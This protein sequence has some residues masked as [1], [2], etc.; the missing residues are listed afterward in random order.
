MISKYELF[1]TSVSSL[2]RDIQKIE[3]I[4]MAKFGL[5]GPHAQCLLVMKRFPQGVTS[6]QL[7]ELCAKDKAAISR[8][9]AELEKARMIRRESRNG[10]IYRAALLLTEQGR[11][12]ADAVSR[13]AKVA[14]ESAGEGLTDAQREVFYHVL[15]VISGNLHTMC[16][17]GLKERTDNKE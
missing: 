12:A 10:N 17:N 13:R 4:E 14:V 11:A 1:S 8:T 3:R 15:S 16:K 9:V 6:A 5:K 7:C 2:Y